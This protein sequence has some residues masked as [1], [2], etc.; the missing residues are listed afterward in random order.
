MTDRNEAI[1]TIRSELK[2]RSGKAWSVRG[3]R[4]TAWGWITIDAPA[5]RHDCQ[6]AHNFVPPAF[7]DCLDC[8]GNRFRDGYADCPAHV[9]NDD[10][11][12]SYMSK[13]DRD[14]LAELLNLTHVHVQ[15]INIPASNAHYDEY[16][17][18]AKGLTPIRRGQQYWD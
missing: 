14:Q 6:R 15:G 11:R 17:A 8:G 1:A 18:R 16:I 2:T 13:A 3:G 9:C 10:C 4:G 7:N 5:A 12:Y